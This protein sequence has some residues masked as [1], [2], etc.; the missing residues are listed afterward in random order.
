MKIIRSRSKSAGARWDFVD[1]MM[2]FERNYEHKDR[3]DKD[4]EKIE[5]IDIVLRFAPML[6]EHELLNKLEDMLKNQRRIDRN[7]TEDLSV[8]HAR[9]NAAHVGITQ[10]LDEA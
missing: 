7:T 10:G 1:G 3:E 4:H 2:Q 8:K 5:A 9:A 6:F